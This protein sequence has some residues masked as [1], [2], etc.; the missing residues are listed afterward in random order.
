MYCP[1]CA[2]PIDGMKFCRTCGTN[3]SLVPQAMTGRLP[4]AVPQPHLQPVEAQNDWGDWGDWHGKRRHRR[5]P[6]LAHGIQTLVSGIGFICVSLGVMAFAP[7][8]RIWW[9]WLLIPAFS[10][11]GSGIA[12]I[13]RAKQ[14]EQQTPPQLPY[15]P[16]SFQSVVQT[17]PAVS[18]PTTSELRL[19]QPPAEVPQSITEH[20]TKHLDAPRRS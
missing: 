5:Q 19:P 9:F 7:A 2:A 8:G 12:Q 4:A 1:N 18:A 20:T 6:S 14:L 17:P 3:V 10:M 16:P 13:V 11:I 15:A